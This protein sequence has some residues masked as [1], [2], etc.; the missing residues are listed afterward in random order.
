MGN[1]VMRH[2]VDIMRPPTNAAVKDLHSWLKNEVVLWLWVAS[3][4]VETKC[5]S[6]VTWRVLM[7]LIESIRAV[8]EGMD[9]GELPEVKTYPATYRDRVVS[10]AATIARSAEEADEELA[11]LLEAAERGRCAGKKEAPTAPDGGAA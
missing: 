8:S 2:E 10:A 9:A 1:S 4:M 3:L 5:D 11:A 7:D 6:D